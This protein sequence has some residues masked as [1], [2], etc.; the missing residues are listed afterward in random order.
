MTHPNLHQLLSE[1]PTIPGDAVSTP[2]DDKRLL[3]WLQKCDSYCFYLL[4]NA[5][6]PVRRKRWFCTFARAFARVCRVLKVGWTSFHARNA[7]AKMKSRAIPW[8]RMIATIKLALLRLHAPTLL[9]NWTR[10]TVMTLNGLRR[11]LD[12]KLFEL[13]SAEKENAQ[14][15][16]DA[17]RLD[18][19][20]RDAVGQIAELE[21]L[22]DKKETQFRQLEADYKQ[23]RAESGQPRA[24]AILPKDQT[25]EN[26]RNSLQCPITFAPFEDPAFVPADEDT[27]EKHAWERTLQAASRADPMYG[28][29]DSDGAWQV[30]GWRVVDKMTPKEKAKATKLFRT[31]KG[32]LLPL[33][34]AMEGVVQ[35]KSLATFA[36]DM[37]TLGVLESEESSIMNANLAFKLCELFLNASLEELKALKARK[38]APK[39]PDPKALW[40]VLQE[41][42]DKLVTR[43][44]DMFTFF[45]KAKRF[46][47]LP[48]G[49][50]VDGWADVNNNW[51][52]TRFVDALR[53]GGLMSAAS[54][55]E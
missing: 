55:A 4:K 18:G 31:P 26:M 49:H 25:V 43:V 54:C 3:D 13:D 46:V 51:P 16:A 38:K 53:D 14:L 28:Y 42:P 45:R 17:N 2:Q 33:A 1:E 30:H 20:C 47:I 15:H 50:T 10:S 24:R 39:K 29:I 36:R 19:E 21:A 9:A 5:T 6:S 8:S 37:K 41:A 34:Q 7:L 11:Q 48:N 23:L 27:Y 32:S 40:K 22:Y 12:E 35:D 52:L 44:S